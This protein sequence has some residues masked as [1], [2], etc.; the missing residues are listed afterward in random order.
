ME[1]SVLSE[2]VD[3]Q[4][5]KI[6]ELETILQEKKDSLRQMEDILQKVRIEVWNECRKVSNDKNKNRKASL[7]PKIRWMEKFYCKLI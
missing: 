3:A 4:S 7:L 2:Q 6:L 5:T 1:V